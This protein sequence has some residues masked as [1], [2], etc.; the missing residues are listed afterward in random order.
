MTQAIAGFLGK[1]FVSADG[2]STYYILGETRE[3]T[4]SLTRDPFDATS[5]DSAGWMEFIQGLGTWELS[6]ESLYLY[7][8]VGQTDVE[9]AILNRTN[10]QFRF[11][12]YNSSGNKG[13][14]GEGIINN[15]EVADTVD[16]AITAS[17]TI[18]GTG[19]LTTYIAA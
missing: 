15:L 4:L 19:S 12:P 5:F 8:D 3:A 16:D 18:T 17:L 10:L 9:N 14:T 6:T 13:Y 1:V 7:A 11:I 2:G